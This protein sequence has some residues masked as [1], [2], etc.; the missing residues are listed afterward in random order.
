MNY[1]KLIVYICLIKY[2]YK[3]N[4]LKSWL[5]SLFLLTKNTPE[6]IGLRITY[7]LLICLIR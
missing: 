1:L 5:I 3:Q 2:W 4:W 6:N 7:L